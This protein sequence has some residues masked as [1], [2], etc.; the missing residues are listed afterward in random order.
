MRVGE[1]TSAIKTLELDLNDI[2]WT[3]NTHLLGNNEHYAAGTFSDSR[4]ENDV[5]VMKVQ[6]RQINGGYTRVVDK[7]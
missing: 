7:Q 4:G 2:R 5:F 1:V 3:V 6:F